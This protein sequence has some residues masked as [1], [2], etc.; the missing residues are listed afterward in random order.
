VQDGSL[1]IGRERRLRHES[2]PNY[3]HIAADVPV[4]CWAAILFFAAAA[5]TC[6]A[7]AR[8]GRRAARRIGRYAL[9]S[10]TVVS[11][12]MSLATIALWVRSHHIVDHLTLIQWESDDLTMPVRPAVYVRSYPGVV[13]LRR[14]FVGVPNRYFSAPA[15]KSIVASMDSLSLAKNVKLLGVRASWIGDGTLWAVTMPHWLLGALLFLLPAVR[16]TLRARR[17]PAATGLCPNCG[18]DLRATPDRCPECGKPASA[19]ATP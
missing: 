14:D 15:D 10:A 3:D 19:S 13:Q 8:S 18:Y 12:A 1:F 11:A 9:N 16:L 17:R 7:L 5:A 4:P 2:A 6:A